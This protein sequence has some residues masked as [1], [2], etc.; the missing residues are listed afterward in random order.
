MARVARSPGF[1]VLGN[2]EQVFGLVEQCDRLRMNVLDLN[3]ACLVVVD[4]FVPAVGVGGGGEDLQAFCFGFVCPA[5]CVGVECQS[6]PVN[7]PE[8]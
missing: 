6:C 5:V 2:A 7:G 4:C 3:H 1:M 8:E